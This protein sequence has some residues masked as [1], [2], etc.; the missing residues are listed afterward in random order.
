MQ[1]WE[2][3]QFVATFEPQRMTVTWNNG[4]VQRVEEVLADFG[5]DGWELVSAFARKEQVM[6]VMKR[7]VE[8]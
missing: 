5:E 3:R 6:Y 8:S 4:S 2:Y 1:R 7:P